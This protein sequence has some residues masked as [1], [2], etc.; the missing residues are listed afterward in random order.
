MQGHP[1]QDTELPEGWAGALLPSPQLALHGSAPVTL[2]P[3]RALAEPQSH[4]QLEFPAVFC[5]PFLL[6]M[7]PVVPKAA[8]SHARLPTDFTG[9]SLT[10]PVPLC[11]AQGQLRLLPQIGQE[12]PACP[13]RPRVSM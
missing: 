10:K 6:A 2:H 11:Q 9:P 8:G 12:A 13:A 3:L 1:P 4:S 7:L 5:P